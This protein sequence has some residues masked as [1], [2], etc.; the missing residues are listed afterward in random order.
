MSAKHS[1]TTVNSGILMTA[2][3]HLGGL[4]LVLWDVN[5]FVLN[6]A[7]ECRFYVSM[8]APRLLEELSRPAHLRATLC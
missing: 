6:V 8:H 7:S 2:V 1:S 5:L 3:E 4:G